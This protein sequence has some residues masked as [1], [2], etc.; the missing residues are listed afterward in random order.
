M[1][2]YKAD[3]DQKNLVVEEIYARVLDAGI[4]HVELSGLDWQQN[5]GLKMRSDD[6]TPTHIMVTRRHTQ[7][8]RILNI[9]SCARCLWKA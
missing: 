7:I 1:C 9:G 8:R 4:F 5:R 3:A 6:K 2:V